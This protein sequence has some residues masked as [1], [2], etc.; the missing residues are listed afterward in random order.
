MLDF[1][2]YLIQL[3][4]KHPGAAPAQVSSRAG[5]SA[6]REVKDLTWFRPDGQEMT[7]AGLAEPPGTRVLGLRLAGDAIDEV[8]DRGNRM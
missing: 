2:R 1:T 8:D 5:R 4:Q 7:D 6:A 3:Y